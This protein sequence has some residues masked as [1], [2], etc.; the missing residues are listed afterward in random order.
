MKVFTQI[1]E[2]RSFIY[3]S[4]EYSSGFGRY[5]KNGKS[6]SKEEYQRASKAY[7]EY[8]KGVDKSKLQVYDT[9]KVDVQ[10]YN[11]K[12]KIFNKLKKNPYKELKSVKACEEYIQKISGFKCSL[13]GITNKELYNGIAENLYKV[14]SRYPYIADNK[15]VEYFCTFGG[16][17]KLYDEKNKEY[18]ISDEE[19]EE[20]SQNDLDKYM[21]SLSYFSKVGT[22]T[23]LSLCALNIFGTTRKKFCEK[24]NINPSE[25][26][27]ERV[28]KILQEEYKN[29]VKKNLIKTY[30][31]YKKKSSINSHQYKNVY[32]LYFQKGNESVGIIFSASNMTKSVTSY[33]NDVDIKFHTKGTKFDSIVTHELGHALD[34]MLTLRLNNK[35]REIYNK[36]SSEDNITN[37]VSKYANTNIQEFISECFAEYI[38]SENP[39][40]IAKQV[41]EIIDDEY[42][43]FVVNFNIMYPRGLA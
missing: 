38:N 40:E 34:S 25:D 42:K 19:L 7:K 27:D 17:N 8:Y 30:N 2:G 9:S 3:Q 21:T 22:H 35:I 29:K 31:S 16:L 10:H 23:G 33:V 41:G 36:L 5:T 11:T 14:L 39:R 12:S 13:Q 15:D 4:D 24:Y 18:D 37:S 26:I 32:G 6:I 43:K 20:I 28:S 1:L